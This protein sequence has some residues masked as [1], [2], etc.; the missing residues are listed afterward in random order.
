MAVMRREPDMAGAHLDVRFGPGAEIGVNDDRPYCGELWRKESTIAA[1]RAV[2][3][4]CLLWFAKRM[5][6]RVRPP[7]NT[8]TNA[9]P[10][11]PPCRGDSG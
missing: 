5:P 2:I 3:C 6:P 11:A 4:I 10:N 9:K 8:A 1:S 7:K